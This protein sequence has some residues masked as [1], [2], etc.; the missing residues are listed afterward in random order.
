MLIVKESSNI[1]TFQ[2]TDNHIEV[3][4]GRMLLSFK[5]PEK[6]ETLFIKISSLT[7]QLALLKNRSIRLF[8]STDADLY[9]NRLY[10]GGVGTSSPPHP[11]NHLSSLAPPCLRRP[12]T[13]LKKRFLDF[14]K[15]FI[16]DTILARKTPFAGSP[17]RRIGKNT[18]DFKLLH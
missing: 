9:Q 4:A 1:P 13:F 3:F 14:Q 10:V 18:S 2:R 15:L 8:V 5:T 11:P 7:Y 16:N 6:G 17:R 12:K